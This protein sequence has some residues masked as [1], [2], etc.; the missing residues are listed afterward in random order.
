[1]L[2][3]EDKSECVML[4]RAANNGIGVMC[5][6]E[7]IERGGHTDILSFR[8]IKTAPRPEIWEALEQFYPLYVVN[9][10]S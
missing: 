8:T 4:G 2:F 7:R 3:G 6:I 1:V 10:R 9:P 5:K